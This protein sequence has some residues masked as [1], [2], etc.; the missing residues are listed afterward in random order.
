VQVLK[1]HSAL[2]TALAFCDPVR[3]E[4]SIGNADDSDDSDDCD[5]FD[6]NGDDEDGSVSDDVSGGLFVSTSLDGTIQTWVRLPHAPRDEWSASTTW[7]ADSPVYA[8][9]FVPRGGQSTLRCDQDSPGKS[10]RVLAGC[11]DASVQVWDIATGEIARIYL[12]HAGVVRAVTGWGFSTSRS[13]LHISGADDGTVK[14]WR[15]LTGALVYTCVGH[16]GPVLCVAAAKHGRTLVSGSADRTL[17]VFA[18]D[19]GRQLAV[20]QGHTDAVVCVTLKHDGLLAVSGSTNK[21]LKV[22][23]C[24]A[25]PASTATA[26]SPQSQSQ[27]ASRTHHQLHH[28]KEAQNA[29]AVAAT[30]TGRHVLVAGA[31]FSVHVFDTLQR[32]VVRILRGHTGRV[33]C[34]GVSPDG[35]VGASGAV[36]GTVRL[37]RFLSKSGGGAPVVCSATGAAVLCLA[38]GGAVV[39]A[40][41]ADG[42]VRVWDLGSGRELVRCDVQTLAFQHSAGLSQLTKRTTLGVPV[43]SP[44]RLRSGSGGTETPVLPAASSTVTALALAPENKLLAIACAT[45]TVYLLALV[46][47]SSG[48]AASTAAASWSY[49]Q[50]C[51]WPDVH[52]AAISGLF[53]STTGAL[54]LFSASRDGFLA[55]WPIAE[56]QSVSVGS[57]VAPSSPTVDSPVVLKQT[58]TGFSVVAMSVTVG[59]AFAVL[60]CEDRAVRV[61]DL[62]NF[63]LLDTFVFD[64]PALAVCIAA[65]PAAPSIPVRPSLSG[66]RPS[67]IALAQV[68]VSATGVPATAAAATVTA[69]AT[70]MMAVPQYRVLVGTGAG[71]LAQLELVGEQFHRVAA[72]F[73]HLESDFGS[74]VTVGDRVM[75]S[76][77]VKD[78]PVD[79]LASRR[80]ALVS[81][82][83]SAVDV[84]TVR[85][86]AGFGTDTPPRRESGDNAPVWNAAIVRYVGELFAEEGNWVGIQLLEPLGALC[87]LVCIFCLILKKLLGDNNGTLFNKS[88]FSCQRG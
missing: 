88:Y 80:D 1:A 30:P 65:I 53:F 55:V 43:V 36:D 69:P 17:R 47:S 26:V 64:S 16:T 12:G 5:D 59:D 63:A 35:R 71:E 70:P 83:S 21:V 57:S 73:G 58:H 77:A 45:G 2:I 76:A 41:G 62:G 9:A 25:A 40:G 10:L 67:S 81:R 78:A 32:R 28:E 48:V 37:W 3:S 68:A 61:L 87:F 11:A 24:P 14:V 75:V 84:L 18:L 19:D 22:W 66:L 49:N 33:L 29:A 72:E 42:A 7:Q 38:M 4:R 50:V 52:A 85:Q 44:T 27:H 8:V 39:A 51:A 86:A 23:A 20:L 56:L 79:P 31:H 54:R 6:N 60:V 15:A 34:V 13:A 82:A 74:T 46:A